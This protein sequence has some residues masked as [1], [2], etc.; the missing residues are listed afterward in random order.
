MSGNTESLKLKWGTLKGWKVTP[1][2]PGHKALVAYSEAG[3]Q[4]FSRMAQADSAEQKRLLCELIDA[5]DADYIVNDF[6]G[7]QM[8]KDDAKA[9]VMEYDA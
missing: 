5:I 4:S 2:S 9:Y 3:N 1:D 6:S 8:T 7:E